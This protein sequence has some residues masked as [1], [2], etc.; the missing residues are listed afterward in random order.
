MS[1]ASSRPFFIT[2][3]LNF[4]FWPYWLFYFPMYFYGLY[5]ALRSRSFMYFS[6][7]NPGMKYSG[8]FG[9]SKYKVLATIPARYV[10]KTILVPSSTP[11]TSILQMI[12]DYHFTYP[13]IIKPDIGERGKD[14]E[15]ISNQKELKDYLRGKPFDLNI[16]EYIDKKLEFGI[17]YHRLPSHKTGNITSVVQKGFLCIK[18]D[19]SNTLQNL[20]KKEIR[21]SK[22][23]EYFE[24]KYQNELASILPNDEIM[25]LEPIGNHCRGTTFYD[26]SNI[27]NDQLTNVFNDIA[28]QIEGYYYGRFDLK[29]ESLNDLY[30]GRNMKIIELNG[31]SSEVAHIYDPNYKLLRAYRDVF[32]HMKYIYDIAKINHANGIKY[33]AL[34]TFLADLQ[35]HIK[36]RSAFR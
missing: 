8:V 24:Q 6:A 31:V 36:N 11:Y 27:I 15:V 1:K 21:I 19:G 28:L 30:H 10:P 17:L 26:A 4:E 16:Q 22:R 3:I 2:K 12:R 18:G 32:K 9:V 25:Y 34:R 29:V 13:F 5:L 20:L 7:T 23:L 35:N 14:V 33:D